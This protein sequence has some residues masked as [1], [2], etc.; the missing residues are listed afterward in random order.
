M[1]SRIDVCNYWINRTLFRN[2]FLKNWDE[3]TLNSLFFLYFF[4]DFFKCRLCN[5]IS[6][7]LYW[8]RVGTHTDDKIKLPIFFFEKL[9]ISF[10]KLFLI[11]ILVD[12]PL[13][14]KE[15]NLNPLK[16]KSLKNL[17]IVFRNPF[18]FEVLKKSF[19]KK[20]IFNSYL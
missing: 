12:F 11:Y 5:E 15:L 7:N 13:T 4:Q 3:I 2:I 10:L 19:F 9:L 16:F 20:I 14:S 17:D 18:F 1:L 8:K 6:G